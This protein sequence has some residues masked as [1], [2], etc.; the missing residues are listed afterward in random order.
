MIR[1][2]VGGLVGVWSGSI[3]FFVAPLTLYVYGWDWRIGS[4]WVVSAA[5]FGSAVALFR[6]KEWGRRSIIAALVIGATLLG[7]RRL[8]PAVRAQDRMWPGAPFTPVLLVLM[9]FGLCHPSVRALTEERPV[10]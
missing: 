3:L 9:A 10:P 8:D 4:L 7:V 6:R 1:A 5:L 2:V